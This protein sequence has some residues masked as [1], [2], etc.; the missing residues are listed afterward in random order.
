[1][2]TQK[3]IRQFFHRKYLPDQIIRNI[4]ILAKNTFQIAS[5]K[6]Y[7]PRAVFSGNTGFFPLMQGSPC[8]TY[9]FGFSTI[10]GSAGIPVHI[11]RPRT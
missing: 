9:L 7:R 8:H 1:L 6:K 5:G 11:A 3:R 10:S 2:Q 4:M